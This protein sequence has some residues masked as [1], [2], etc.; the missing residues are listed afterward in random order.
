MIC[1]YS[2]IYARRVVR[3]VW[4]MGCRG[5]LEVQPVPFLDAPAISET[6]DVEDQD[7]RC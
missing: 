4:G 6:D 3:G 2:D 5:F 1:I 7:S